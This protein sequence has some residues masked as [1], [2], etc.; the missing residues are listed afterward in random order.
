MA[1]LLRASRSAISGIYSPSA[2]VPSCLCPP[3]AA[4]ASRM[5]LY[6]ALIG[7]A[8]TVAVGIMSAVDWRI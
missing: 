6:S 7:A 2:A 5:A 8:R 4:N 3:D 1:T